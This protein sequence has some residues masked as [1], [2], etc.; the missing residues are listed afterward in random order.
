MKTL[1]HFVNNTLCSVLLI[2]RSCVMFE[3]KDFALFFDDVSDVYCSCPLPKVSH[4][5]MGKKNAT[6]TIDVRQYKDKKR[7]TEGGR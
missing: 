2:N 3:Y 6:A 5:K 4:D 7:K 1:I